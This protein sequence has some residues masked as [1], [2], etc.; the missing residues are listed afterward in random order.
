[1]KHPSVQEL[2]H[3]WNTRRGSRAAPERSDIEPAAIRR[4]LADTFILAHAAANGHW[5]RI[6][7]TRLCAAFGRELRGT[8]FVN[9]W[10]QHSA[11]RISDLLEEVSRESVGAVAGARGCS[12]NGKVLDFELV[13]LP[14]QHQTATDARVLGALAPQDLPYWFGM[15]PVGKLALGTIR[16]LGHESTRHDAQAGDAGEP[17]QGQEPLPAGGRIRHGLIVY[18]GGQA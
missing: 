11:R 18:D 4:A 1:M 15:S 14:L 8:A 16:Y 9:L 13:L 17:H 3:Y 2:Y 5:F 12:P 6:A 7:G 10:D